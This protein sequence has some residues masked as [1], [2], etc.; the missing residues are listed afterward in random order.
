MKE[1]APAFVYNLMLSPWTG[2]CLLNS[3]KFNMNFDSA[4]SIIRS[5]V[6]LKSHLRVKIALCLTLNI[7]WHNRQTGVTDVIEDYETRYKYSEIREN[8]MPKWLYFYM[9]IMLQ[10]TCKYATLMFGLVTLYSSQQ[11]GAKIIVML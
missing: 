11:S 5:I 1:E 7:F 4:L 8:T 9:Y 2:C 10:H 3:L 6:E